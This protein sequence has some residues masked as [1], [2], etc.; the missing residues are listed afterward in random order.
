M[1]WPKVSI[2]VTAYLKESKAYLD[3]CVESIKRLDYPQELIDV[4]IV[5][6]MW[7]QPEYENCRTIHP[8]FGS[9]HNPVAIN[10]GAAQCAYDSKHILFLNDDVILTENSLKKM[11]LIAGDNDVIIG[12]ISNCDNYGL[13]DADLPLGLNKRQYRMEEIE[14]KLE[15]MMNADLPTG[16]VRTIRPHTLYLYANLIPRKVWTR[17]KNGTTPE[18]IGFDE[19]F[20]TGFDDTDYCIRS[21]NAGV[22]LVIATDVL[23]WHCSGTSADV[24]M[25]D[26]KS[27]LREQN[28]RY[29]RQKWADK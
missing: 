19:N 2:V 20:K 10:F 29:F 23:I 16:P 22:F 27:E 17:V 13:F 21:R 5:T 12:P 26:L 8:C 28:E 3:A 1:T 25:G 11:V 15:A 7:F 9:Y 4:V 24:T 18:S 6:P 14:S